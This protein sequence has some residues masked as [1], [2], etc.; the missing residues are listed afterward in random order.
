MVFCD[1][2][3]LLIHKSQTPVYSLH[4]KITA[5][6]HALGAIRAT[7]AKADELVAKLDIE[8]EEASERLSRNTSLQLKFDG[9]VHASTSESQAMRSND[10]DGPPEIPPLPFQFHHDDESF[11]STMDSDKVLALTKSFSVVEDQVARRGHFRDKTLETGSIDLAHPPIISQG[12][13]PSLSCAQYGQPSR[14]SKTSIRRGRSRTSS[15][16][17]PRIFTG[18]LNE[19]ENK[20]Y[21]LNI[22]KIETPEGAQSPSTADISPSNCPSPVK[23]RDFAD[24]IG[25]LPV[26]PKPSLQRVETLVGREV[27]W[28]DR[29]VN[30]QLLRSRR[31]SEKLQSAHTV[32]ENTEEFCCWLS[33]QSPGFSREKPMPNTPDAASKHVRMHQRER[34][35]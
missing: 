7:C 14:V 12:A 2:T 3:D 11:L 30:G 35:F 10:N 26:D 21:A 33:Q 28:E 18:T 16:S 23:A 5:I 29:I 22:H 1:F 24:D 19:L 4:I 32:A 17:V 27:Q 8:F 13:E 15:S 25:S 6:R 31:P 20:V 9:Q 34:T